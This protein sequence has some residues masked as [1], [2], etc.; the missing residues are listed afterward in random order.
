M[1]EHRGETILQT[2]NRLEREME[3]L[4]YHD[5]NLIALELSQ[6]KN[7]F[8]NRSRLRSA[9]KPQKRVEDLTKAVLHLYK[10]GVP[11]KEKAEA[12]II[13]LEHYPMFADNNLH[14]KN[15]IDKDEL[16]PFVTKYFQEI[17]FRQ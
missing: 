6:L 16:L 17:D 4:T 10:E 11:N 2:F 1:E 12:W 9:N 15:K 13:L 8:G 7:D 5:P 3:D 14:P